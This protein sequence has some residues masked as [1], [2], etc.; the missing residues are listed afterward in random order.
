MDKKYILT[1]EIKKIGDGITLHR[2]KA[3]K[4]FDDVKAGDLG[5][6]VESEDNLSHWSKA[7]VYD[8]AMV[9]HRAKVGGDARVCHSATVCGD[10]M[11]Q[12][13][14][15]IFGTALVAGTAV[16]DGHASVYG[17][18]R[19]LGDAVVG[20]QSVIC[21]QAILIG[22]VAVHDYAEICGNIVLGAG[23]F[24]DNARIKSDDDYIFVKGLGSAYRAT[25]AFRDEK[26]GVAISCGC[27]LGGLPEFKKAVRATHGRNKFA[28]EYLA[29]IKVIK[30]H[31]DI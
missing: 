19:V 3:L 20:G 8:D 21:G 10:A 9:Y 4:S 18:A 17:K 11:V 30:A 31:F 25:T 12:E 2:I 1:D 29:L 24:R 5:G 16:I 28:K 23:N 14:A 22:S 15:R 6:W 27:F 26:L 13:Q 7:W